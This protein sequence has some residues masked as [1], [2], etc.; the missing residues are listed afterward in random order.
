MTVLAQ[1]LIASLLVAAT[2]AVPATVDLGYSQYE[3]RVLSNGITQ[4]LGMRYAAAPVGELRF[5]PPQDPPQM[6]AVQPATDVSS[7][8][9]T[10]GYA[11]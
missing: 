10:L 2:T 4:W 7:L 6:S 1:S 9:Q 5:M 8:Q 11:I 3:G